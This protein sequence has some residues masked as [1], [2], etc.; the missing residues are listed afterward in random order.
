LSIG[1]ASGVVCFTLIQKKLANWCKNLIYEDGDGSIWG[2]VHLQAIV[3]RMSG[4]IALTIPN[5][6]KTAKSRL[7]RWNAV[8]LGND[9]DIGLLSVYKTIFKT[10]IL[11]SKERGPVDWNSRQGRLC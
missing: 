9:E 8:K 6:F 4:D 7:S 1:A 5:R 3:P 10:V 2:T 11:H